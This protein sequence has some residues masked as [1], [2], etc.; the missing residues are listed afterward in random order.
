MAAWND[1]QI[2]VVLATRSLAPP[3]HAPAAGSVPPPGS[4]RRGRGGGGGRGGGDGPARLSLTVAASRSD[5]V[6]EL[7]GLRASAMA[8]LRAGAYLHWLERH[9]CERAEVV[10]ALDT[11]GS[12]VSRYEELA[13]EA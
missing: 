11:V 4:S 5:T 10:E 7:Q 12:I 9:G 2:N 8:K 13:R 6:A 1:A 3:R